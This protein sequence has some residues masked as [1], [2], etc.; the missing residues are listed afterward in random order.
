MRLKTKLVLASTVFSTV[1]TLALLSIFFVQLLRVRLDA[2]AAANATLGQGLILAE[3]Q[4]L[5]NGL[6]AQMAANSGGEAAL[7]QAVT[8]ALQAD[9]P[10]RENME[11]IVRYAPTVQDVLVT[12]ANGRVLVST[13]PLLEGQRPPRRASFDAAVHGT[14]RTQL[15]LIFGKPEVLDA[16]FA[17]RRNGQPFLFAHIGIRST[18]LRNALEPW[19][20]QAAW[21]GSLALGSAFAAALLLSSLALRP[22]ERIVRRLEDLGKDSGAKPAAFVEPEPVVEPALRGTPVRRRD[23][24]READTSIARIDERMRR[25]EE[26]TTDLQSNL[27]QMLHTLQDGVLL[28]NAAGAILLASD[29]VQQFLPDGSHASAGVYLAHIFPISTPLGSLLLTALQ[30]RTTL[31]RAASTL[32]DGRQVEVTLT[33]PP[34]SVGGPRAGFGAMLTLHN[35]A[36]QQAVEQEIEV[37]RRLASIGR[38]TAGV[39]HEVKNPI[40]AMVLHL[41]LLRGKLRNP[42]AGDPARHVEVLASEMSRLDRVVQTLAD[43]TRPLEPEL[44]QQ[45]LRP[46]VDA[47]LQLVSVDAAERGISIRLD[48][49]EPGLAANVDGELLHQALLNIV[50]NG[51]DAM[52]EGG[53][54]TVSLQRSSGSAQ[55]GVRDTGHGI[56][57]ELLDRIFHLYF[58]TKS[59]G[60]GIGLA[61]TWR[62]VQM[63]GGTVQVRSNTTPGNDLH[64]T[65]FTVELPLGKGRQNRASTTE[66]HA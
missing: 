54:L 65:L 7:E 1:L 10:L 18:L 28:L 16:G 22:L 27:S 64:G 46:I 56:P 63:M 26:L 47:V 32:P 2:T 60:T 29:A 17:L 5:S 45:P 9:A 3:R 8:D 13:D 48:D 14:L 50:L 25:S 12:G 39:G 36:A 59:T 33:F 58:T 23:A 4:A 30:E 15:A 61:M 53:T 38:L 20:K 62:I 42:G 51:M 24:L 37:G 35:S 11:A 19:L 66:A 31:H 21:I 34:V 52:T 43:F 55:I 57:P 44:R 41:E 49:S 6:P 40:N